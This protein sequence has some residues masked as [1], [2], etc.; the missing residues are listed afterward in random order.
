MRSGRSRA[1]SMPLAGSHLG[2][3]RPSPLCLL[4][5]VGRARPARR[6]RRGVGSPRAGRHGRSGRA[7]IG[8]L[9]WSLAA[10]DQ[11]RLIV[12]G[13]PMIASRTRPSRPGRSGDRL[14][15]LRLGMPR[16]GLGAAR[17]GRWP[18]RAA[19]LALLEI[20]GDQVADR[21]VE[22]EEQAHHEQERA[23][24]PRPR[25]PQRP[26]QGAPRPSPPLPRPRT[27]VVGLIPPPAARWKAPSRARA[28]SAAP[29]A[30]IQRSAGMVFIH[31]IS[32]NPASSGGANAIPHPSRSRAG[33]A[34]A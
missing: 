5:V 28:T 16:A 12:L 24:W 6:A 1:A 26:A 30:A 20:G 19:L 34:R 27:V 17:R 3:V 32:A 13:G 18:L 33:R 4:G 14:D 21:H 10:D 29:V 11:R 23:G 9:G 31:S 22:V 8:H 25:G 2:P 15:R 7:G